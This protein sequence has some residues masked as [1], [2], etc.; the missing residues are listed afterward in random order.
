M[1]GGRI[2]LEAT[3]KGAKLLV[4]ADGKPKRGQ[5]QIAI[6]WEITSGVDRKTH[7][8]QE[9]ETILDAIRLAPDRTITVQYDAEAIS[10][11]LRELSRQIWP[12]KQYHVSGVAYR[13]LFASES[14]AAGVDPADLAAAM[15]HLSSESQGR[16]SSRP[17]RSGGDTPIKSSKG[18]FT[19]VKAH[20]KVKTDRSPMSR[21][22]RS[23]SIK[24]NFKS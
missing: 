3:V 5:K 21:F 16:Y 13:E 23:N 24:K 14:K 17:R 6:R 4:D 2:Y 22:K 10:T 12:R 7:R 19:S 8:P 15:S 1:E 20:T 18:T 9:F 11:R